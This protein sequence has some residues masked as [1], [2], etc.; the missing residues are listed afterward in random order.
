MS[1]HNSNLNQIIRDKLISLADDKYR[2]FASKL[3][4]GTKNILGVQIPKL[5]KIA[6]EIAKQDW[7]TYLQ[8]FNQIYNKNNLNNNCYFEEIMLQGLVI[9]CIKTDITTIIEYLPEFVKKIDNWSVCDSFCFNLKITE[10]NPSCSNHIYNFILPYF[11]SKKEFEIRFAVVMLLRWFNKEEL[12]S[13]NLNLLNS[14]WFIN[15]NNLNKNN[16]DNYYSKMAVAWAISVFFA[17][18]PTKI[19]QYLTK[20]K[21]NNSFDQFVLNKALQKIKES[22][23]SG[24]YLKYLKSN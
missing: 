9:G 4:P 20:N 12:I 19:S 10:K 11:E 14:I 15:K 3:L 16:F 1:L 6:K 23:K 8:Q 21:N 17:T 22:K 7:K 2:N 18:S 24:P 13:Q 5:R